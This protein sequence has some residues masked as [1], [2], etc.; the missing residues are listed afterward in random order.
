MLIGGGN[1]AWG[2]QTPTAD[3]IYYLYNTGITSGGPGFMSTGDNYGFQVVIDNFGFPVKL[4]ST[5]TANTY[6]LQFIHHEG[7]LSDDGFMYS[8]GGNTGDNPRARTITVQDQGDGKYKLINTSNSKEIE[9]WYGQVVGDGTGDRRDYIWQFLSK[10]ERNAIVAG[11]TSSV[12][13]AAAT[14]MGMPASVD[15]ESEFDDY[16]STNYIGVDQSAK[17]TNGT[18][19]TNHVTTDWT[20]TANSN[21]D[22]NIVWGNVDPKTTPE[23]YQGAGYLK[24]TQITVDK[25][26]L[27]KVSVNAT[28]RCGN[29]D[30]NNRIG[31]LG[32]DGSVAYLKANNNIAKISDWYSGK[33]NGNGPGSPSEANSTYF[34]AGKY[35]TEVYVYIGDEKTLDIELHSHAMTWG[36]W[37]MFNNFKLTYYNNEVSDDDAEALLAT[38]PTE[39]MLKATKDALDDAV[40]AFESEQTIANYNALSTAID[41]ANA[42]I[43]VYAPLGVKLTE[44]G[45]VKT[46]VNG[47]APSYITTF[48]T[49]IGTITSNYTGGLIAESG[50]SNQ[51]TAVET[52]ILKL[53]KS[54][55]TTGSDMTRAVPNAACTSAADSDN[56]KIETALTDGQYFRLDTWAGTASGMSVPMIEY[57]NANG[58]PLTSNVIYQTITGLQNGIYTVAATTAVNN[59]SN[60]APTAGSALLFANDETKDIT[61]GGTETSFKGQTGTFSV[62]VVLTDADEGELKIGLKAVSPN[63]NWIAFKNVTLTYYGSVADSDDYDALQAAI[64]AKAENTHP[65]GFETGEY[66]PYN[67]IALLTALATAKAIDQDAENAKSIV[68]DAT[69]TLSGT[70][71]S[72]ANGSE[73]NAFNNGDF[74]ECAEDETTPLDYTPAGWTATAN[75]RKMLKNSTINPGLTDASANSAV[76]TWSGGIT[77]GETTGYTM[78][79]KAN[80]VY[81]LTFK[82]SGWNNETRSGITVSVLKDG[83][84]GLNSIDLGTPDKDIIGNEN[85]VSGM[86]SFSKTFVTGTAGNYVFHVQSGHNF[87]ITDLELKRANITIDENIAYAN[88]L[89]G[90]AN[91]TLN[92]TILNGGK[93]NTFCVP[94]DID[95]TTLKAKFGSDVAVAEYS[96]TTSSDGVNSKVSFNT[97]AT[98]AIT[99]NTPVLLKTSTTYS[100]ATFENCV[101]KTGDAI[102]S[103]GHEFDFVGSYAATTEVAEGDYYISSNTIYRSKGIGSYVKGTRA[104]IKAKEGGEARINSFFIDDEETTD[105]NGIDMKVIEQTGK[106][107]NLNGQ[108]VKTAR[109]GLY[110]QNG[111]KIIK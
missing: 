29:N 95:N 91:V 101:L 25:V 40:S 56:W 61:S 41:N 38:V 98:P 87:C 86:T 49:N 51:V 92:R 106:I 26:G 62:N 14:S 105:I 68:N 52:E 72:S 100:P 9:N 3:G 109:K 1:L 55:T 60:V 75:M 37:L 13:L 17:I 19:D 64:D 80:T 5:G 54:Q 33:I 10:D 24:H 12:K 71:W 44:A 11:Y 8:D 85:N 58:N 39:P 16:L 83:T 35:L 65:L 45:N 23:V 42:S 102:V 90:T 89:A 31:D 70:S 20:T 108:E 69:S 73:Q 103:G 82:A 110:I 36:G 77:Y 107:Y 18:F 46:S 99:A 104:Y 2:Y 97:M 111:K 57:W 93:W 76:M 66:A 74:S 50:I 79:L 4:I 22:F 43:S 84:Y 28:Y 67:N 21:R 96:E 30:N 6:Q 27:Y 7:Y 32:Y 59:E 15:T 34:S 94:F 47:N 48:D 81:T 88:E 78:P 53:V 63:Y